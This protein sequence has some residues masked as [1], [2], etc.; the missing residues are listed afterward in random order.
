MTQDELRV[1]Y[2]A[3]IA[4][5]TQT[6]IASV[7]GINPSVLS[8][9]RNGKIDLY[10]DLFQKLRDFFENN[11]RNRDSMEIKNMQ[12]YNPNMR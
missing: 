2:N 7:T 6:Y 5:G 4:E 3:H 11:K 1:I 8:R 10:P 9:F 12:E